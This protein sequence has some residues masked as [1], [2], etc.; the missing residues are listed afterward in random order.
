MNAT[1]QEG[2]KTAEDLLA[3]LTELNLCI[4]QKEQLIAQINLVNS[5]TLVN[6]LTLTE[7]RPITIHI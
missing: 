2:E 5:R 3:L 7:V 4:D 1:V 6:G